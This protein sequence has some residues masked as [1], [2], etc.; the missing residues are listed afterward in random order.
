VADAA[1]ETEATDASPR[2]HPD[3]I[4]EPHVQPL[5][6]WRRHA[7]PLSLAAFGSIVLLAMIGTLG[8]ERDWHARAFGVELDVHAPEVIRNGEFLE[9][10][11]GVRSDQPIGELVIGIE[12]ALWRDL[13]VNTMI[14]AASEETGTDGEMRF[15][16]AELPAGTPFLFK[17]DLQVNPDILLGNEG[18][19]TV[20]DG[21]SELVATS[22]SIAVL[23]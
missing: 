10:R 20:Y 12:E 4:G 2:R 3:G 11:I 21:D 1:D 9:M 17:V 6:S 16:F 7:S 8:H 13:T 15:T 5:R 18:T 14:P 23:P 22:I 19:I